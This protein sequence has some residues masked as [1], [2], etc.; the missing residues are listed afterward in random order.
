MLETDCFDSEAVA[1]VV[2]GIVL[3]STHQNIYGI[4]SPGAHILAVSAYML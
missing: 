1:K 2:K 3:D 4:V